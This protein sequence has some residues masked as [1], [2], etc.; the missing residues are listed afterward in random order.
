MKT[1]GTLLLAL[2]LTAAL[3][4]TD[5]AG[6]AAPAYAGPAATYGSVAQKATNAQRAKRDLRKLK[7]N[8]CLKRYA[9][10]QAR[11]MARKQEIWHQD[12]RAVMDACGL[13]SVGENVAAGYPTGKAVVNRGWMTSQGHREN[14]LR[15]GWTLGVVAARKDSGGVWYAAQLFGS[16]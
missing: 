8:R 5:L 7:T 2:V 9:V 11:A 13:S 10:K 14:I 15:P 4:V 1:L 16:R 6:P 3:A 12:L